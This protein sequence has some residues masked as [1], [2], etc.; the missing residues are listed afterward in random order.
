MRI[1]IFFLI[2]LSVFCLD[3]LNAQKNNKKIKITGTV[4]NVVKEPVVNAI[5]LIDGKKT[6]SLTDHKG[7]FKVRVNPTASTIGFFTFDNGFAEEAINGR[8]QINFNF[9]TTVK[10]QIP[11]R[12]VPC[13]EQ[14]VNTGYSSIKMKNL[15]TDISK[16]DGTNSKYTSYSSISEMIQREVSGVRISGGSVIIQESRDF[17]GFLPALVMVDGVSCG[18]DLPEIPPATVKSIEVLKGTSGAIFGSRGL[19]G[20]III[21]TKLSEN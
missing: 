18:Y 8:T 7:N 3:S 17:L 21:K 11:D 16:I 2:L 9:E 6:Y 20:A 1:K 14:G 19:G 12:T 13:G 4:L 15:V 10:H 5:V